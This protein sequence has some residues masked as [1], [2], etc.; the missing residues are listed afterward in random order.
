MSIDILFVPSHS[1]CESIP[2]S[3][4]V[5][6]KL[7][8][9]KEACLLCK[10]NTHNSIDWAYLLVFSPNNIRSDIQFQCYLSTLSPR[11]RL[12]NSPTYFL[13]DCLCDIYLLIW[14]GD[15]RQCN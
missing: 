10:L 15:S 2:N 6:G 14:M 9:K 12:E 13:L 1:L 8:F 11:S 3:H 4:R 7:R 5:N